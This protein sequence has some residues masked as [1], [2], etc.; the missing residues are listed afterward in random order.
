MSSPDLSA[1]VDKSVDRWIQQARQEGKLEVF[2]SSRCRVCQEPVIMNMVNKML[3]RG[4]TMYDIMGTLESH[5]LKR[6]LDRQPEITRACLYAHRAR[7]FDVQS[8]AGAILRRIQEECAVQFGQDWE[9]GVGTILN[10]ASY[11]QTMMIKGYETLIDPRTQV[12]PVDGGKAAEKLDEMKRKSEGDLDRAQ[13]RVQYGRMIEVLRKFTDPQDW[14]QI[15]AVLRGE[16]FDDL[17][18]DEDIQIVSIN[19]QVEEE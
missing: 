18:D 14:P 2:P 13:M 3:A 5:N 11:Y 8:P 9:T 10:V 4:F 6:K 12:S 17:P 1:W 15:Q 19:D 7:H 16:S